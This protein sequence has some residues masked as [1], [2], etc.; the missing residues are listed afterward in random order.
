MFIFDS[1]HC[2]GHEGRKRIMKEGH[3]STGVGKKKV[4]PCP[5]TLE[6]N[7]VDMKRRKVTVIVYHSGSEKRA[8]GRSGKGQKLRMCILINAIMKPI[9]L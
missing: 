7:D 3:G 1:V 4:K 2:V 5:V 8:N 6:Q 9:I